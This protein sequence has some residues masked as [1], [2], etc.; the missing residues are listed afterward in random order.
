[1]NQPVHI[2]RRRL[3][4]RMTALTLGAGFLP[5]LNFATGFNESI[6]SAKAIYIAPGE[7]KKGKVGDMD[8]TFKLNK[9]QTS[10]HMGLWESI[11][12]PGELGA[13][14]HL[15]KTFDEICH[16][17]EGS[18]FI[19]TGDD[20]TEVKAG[21]WHLRPKGVVHTFWN[22]SNAPAKT[23]DICLP[24][25]HEDY[26]IDLAALFENGNRPKPGDFK[27]L[28]EQYDIQYRFDLLADIMKQ[29]KVK[30]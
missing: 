7:G 18:V 17:K 11:I 12:Q 14:P 24:G 13:P 25:G 19:M 28:S 2:N 23:I 1:M 8:I 4:Q 20:I 29:Y 16:V 6:D 15:H 10:G 9:Q 5:K 30:L 27:I 3:I 26:M 22:S 21:G